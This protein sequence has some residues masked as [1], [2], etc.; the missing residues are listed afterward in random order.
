MNNTS[1][2]LH[3]LLCFNQ[4]V[5]QNKVKKK[6]TFAGSYINLPVLLKYT[7]FCCVFISSIGGIQS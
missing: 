2:H 7:K 1:A 4:D 6:F 3:V 5:L